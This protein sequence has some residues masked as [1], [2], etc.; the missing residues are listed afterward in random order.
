MISRMLWD[1]EQR[2]QDTWNDRDTQASHSTNHTMDVNRGERNGEEETGNK[3][4]E[5]KE[6]CDKDGL[7]KE[8]QQE[9]ESG[10]KKEDTSQED[11][12]TTLASLPQCQIDCLIQGAKRKVHQ[13]LLS[14]P[15]CGEYTRVTFSLVKGMFS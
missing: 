12:Q 6:K 3:E 9:T 1:L 11:S 8:S 15:T 4:D 13:P 10:G 5:V 2:Y 7:K 14:R